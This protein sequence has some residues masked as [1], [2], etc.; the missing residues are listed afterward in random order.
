[1]KI[2]VFIGLCLLGTSLSASAQLKVANN[3]RIYMK[4][5][6]SNGNT[7]VNIGELADSMTLLNNYNT[8]LRSL[9]YNTSDSGHAIGLFGESRHLYSESGYS[10]MGVWGVGGGGKVGRNIGVAGTLHTGR[11]GA[12]IYGTNQDNAFFTILSNFAGFFYGPIRVE[13]RV[14]T[15]V[16]FF[17][18]SDIRLKRNVVRMAEKERYSGSTL[19]NLASLDVLRP[20]GKH[21][22]FTDEIRAFIQTE[23][24][25]LQKIF[26]ARIDGCHQ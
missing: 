16:G 4:G 18:V 15:T 24:I 23:E 17:D 6:Y 22:F 2:I 10:S 26:I 9:F 19:G 11:F 12:G 13:G 21:C 1:M 20:A 3:G 7:F 5:D 14:T 25:F 8:G